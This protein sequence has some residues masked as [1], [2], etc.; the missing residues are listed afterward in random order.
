MNII[1]IP[2]IRHIGIVRNKEVFLELP[3]NNN[4]ESYFQTQH[5]GLQF[6]LAETAS[7][8]FLQKT[9]SNL[10]RK[11]IPVLRRSKI[12]F[13]KLSKNTIIAFSSIDIK[14]KNNFLK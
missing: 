12:K 7:T 9:F 11:S 3:F 5:A 6:T 2:F 1:D 10:V 13:K 14:T 8:D 4:I